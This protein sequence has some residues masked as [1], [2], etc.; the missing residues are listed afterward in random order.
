[1]SQSG[2]AGQQS[3]HGL[4]L[5]ES[6]MRFLAI[7]FLLINIPASGLFLT[8]ERYHLVTEGG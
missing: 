4:M 5:L 8:A 6:V 3:P 7:G 1:M 2:L